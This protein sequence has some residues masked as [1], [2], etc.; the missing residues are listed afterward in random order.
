MR[1]F[2]TTFAVKLISI[3][4]VHFWDNL[5]LRSKLTHIAIT[6]AG[7]LEP[8]VRTNY[9]DRDAYNEQ[10]YVCLE[11]K[12][13]NTSYK[14]YGRNYHFMSRNPRKFGSD[15]CF[16]ILDV[17][18]V[19]SLGD[20][21]TCCAEARVRPRPSSDPSYSLEY[22]SLSVVSRF[23]IVNSFIR[24]H[25]SVARRPL[26]GICITVSISLC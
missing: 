12:T 4:L 19:A 26:S 15:S 20:A 5:S 10:R 18:G 3:L 21:T 13:P 23:M 7:D 6:T 8:T 11:V 16:L 25:L 1:G 22:L 24:S 17:V 2:P 14:N 9:C